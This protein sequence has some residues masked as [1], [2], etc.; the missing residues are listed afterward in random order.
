MLKGQAASL[1]QELGRDEE[2][3]LMYEEAI[4]EVGEQ[5]PTAVHSLDRK[6]GLFARLGRLEEAEATWQRAERCVKPGTLDWREVQIFRGRLLSKLG[7]HSE[8]LAVFTNLAAETDIGAS[9]RAL[10]L[11]E[12]AVALGLAGQ[13]VQADTRAAE[14]ESLLEELT[15]QEDADLAK[16]IRGR[17]RLA[18]GQSSTK[19]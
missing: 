5:D 18:R 8:A 11:G 9:D 6:A 15:S 4:H 19:D 10:A 14:T 17:L 1:L 2:A 3:L 13:A 16:F 12:L 7:K